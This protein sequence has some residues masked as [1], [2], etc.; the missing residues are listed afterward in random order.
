VEIEFL[1]TLSSA[2]SHRGDMFPIRLAEPLMA[3]GQVLLPA[4]ALGVGEVVEPSLRRGGHAGRADPGGALSGCGRGQQL[5]LRAL[6]QA[7]TGRIRRG[8]PTMRCGAAR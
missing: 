6:Q 3:G 7:V 2:S 4:G 8:A 5:R 1:T